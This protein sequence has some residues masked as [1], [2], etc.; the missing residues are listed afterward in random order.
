MPDVR[1]D[2]ELQHLWQQGDLAAMEQF[3]EKGDV[4]AQR[5][6]GLMLRNRSRFDEAI[7]WY[8]RA[9]DQGDGRSAAEIADFYE[10]GIGRPRDPREALS[11]HRKAAALG[12]TSSQI[13][14]ASALSRGTILPR[15]EREAFKWYLKASAGPYERGYA[16][17]PIAEMY[18][19]GRAVPRDLKRAHAYAKAA[20]HTVDNSDT[21]SLRKAASLQADVAARLRPDELKAAERLYERLWPDLVRRTQ[22]RNQ[23]LLEIFAFL[24]AL[25]VGVLAIGWHIGRPAGRTARG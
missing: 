16:Y 25:V 10:L 5:W 20:E 15:N 7:H 24:V 14:Y 11:W 2:L 17:L 18:V 1:H 9:V 4:R 12:S 13:R 8:G 3:A 19:E 21:D 23:K 22:V 6:M